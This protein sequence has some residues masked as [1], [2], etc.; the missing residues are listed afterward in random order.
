MIYCT[1]LNNHSPAAV[2]SGWANALSNDCIWA[3]QGSM[4]EV[5]VI[6]HL[7]SWHTSL[8]FMVPANCE[9]HL[10]KQDCHYTFQATCAV[11]F[12]DTRQSAS[13]QNKSLVHK[14]KRW[15]SKMRPGKK[16]T[17]GIRNHSSPSGDPWLPWCLFTLERLILIIIVL[18]TPAIW[19]TSLLV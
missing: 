7:F 8:L 17:W 16:Y 18:Y 11:T 1:S 12:L 10:T 3:G 9:G 4:A 13:K 2:Q 15:K 19:I 5:L 14:V 6:R